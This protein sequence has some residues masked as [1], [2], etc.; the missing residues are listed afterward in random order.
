MNAKIAVA[1][2]A[3]ALAFLGGV[4]FAP[5]LAGEAAAQIM[6]GPVGQALGHRGPAVGADL[7]QVA[8]DYIGITP[9]E[10]RDEM[11]SDK[12]MADVAIAHGKTRDGLVAALTAAVGTHIEALV[13]HKGFPAR[14]AGPGPGVKGLVLGHS[15]QAALDYLGLTPQE[16]MTQLREGKS[17]GQIADATDGKSRQ[18]LID[19]IVADESAKVDQA[20]TNGRITAEQAERMKARLSERVTQWVDNTRPGPLGFGLGFDRGFRGFHF[21]PDQ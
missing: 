6:N 10:L 20:Q 18:G 1:A 16:V 12:S 11:G 2:G 3:L 9:Q 21:G 4:A 13:D 15:F 19:A 17:L 7:F 5:S 14:D 8:A